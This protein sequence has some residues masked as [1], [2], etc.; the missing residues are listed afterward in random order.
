M[1]HRDDF[2]T[3]NGL[4]VDFSP[5]TTSAGVSLSGVPDTRRDKSLLDAA[6]VSRMK[7]KSFESYEAS[8]QGF[9]CDTGSSI[10]RQP[11]GKLMSLKQ[12]Q[13]IYSFEMQ[14]VLSGWAAMRLHGWKDV[15]I[16]VEGVS[17]KEFKSLAG[18]AFALPPITLIHF[19]FYRNPFAPWWAGV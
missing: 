10:P 18:E 8:K 13:T 3:Q 17:D 5:W 16:N 14:F 2:M 12:D 15:G 4:V 19:A 1:K 7:G 11:W 6:W 9:F